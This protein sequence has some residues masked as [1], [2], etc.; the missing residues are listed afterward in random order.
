M[1]ELFEKLANE[2]ERPREL[3][4]RVL[5]YISG[6]YGVDHDAIGAFLVDE[7]S[8]LE[9]YEID[10]ALSPLFTPKLA[11]QAVFAELLG[12]QSVSS[13]QIAELTEQ[14]AERPTVAQLVTPDDRIH[15]VRLQHVT[16]ERFVR[17]LRLEGSIPESFSALL[18][19]VSSQ[20]QAGRPTLRAVGRRAVW[21]NEGAREILVRYLTN[22][23]S[24][25]GYALTDVLD[26]LNLV[27]GRKPA[28]LA[29][30]LARIG[31]WRKALQEQVDAGSGPKAFFHEDIRMMHGGE[32]DQ[33]AEADARYSAKERE[34]EFLLRLEKILL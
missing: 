31:G 18:D 34:L 5:N 10:L 21:E 23:P 17:R 19:Q 29:D 12:G 6:T 33:R 24:R 9:D 7:L 8:K 32:R 20:D 2:L 4:P 22:A 28:S 25:G 11:D 15:R 27:E 13:D 16:I 3:T 1:P 26:L 30:L 14:L